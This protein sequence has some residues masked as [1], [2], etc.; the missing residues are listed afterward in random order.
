LFIVELR[1]KISNVINGLLRQFLKAVGLYDRGYRNSLSLG[2]R[3]QDLTLQNLPE[4]FH[5]LRILFMSDLHLGGMKE[6][7]DIIVERIRDIEVDICLLGGDYR[8]SF[9]YPDI[10]FLDGLKKVLSKIHAP[11]GIYG[12]MGNHDDRNAIPA[13]ERLGLRLL[14]N[15]SVALERGGQT[16]HLVGVDESTFYRKHDLKKAFQD[17]PFSRCL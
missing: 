1:V 10:P 12:V 3:R 14:L 6:L 2:V 16:I 13:I 5:N 4:N 9:T 17:V 7:P 8:F 15:K 11:L